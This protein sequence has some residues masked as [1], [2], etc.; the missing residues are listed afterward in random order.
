MRE[1]LFSALCS[2]YFMWQ[3]FDMVN[4]KDLDRFAMVLVGASLLLSAM[5]YNDEITVSLGGASAALFGY[6]VHALGSTPAG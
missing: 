6:F 4:R 5:G 1:I 3:G 2:M